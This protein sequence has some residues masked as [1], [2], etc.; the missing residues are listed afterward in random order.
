MA[1]NDDGSSASLD[2]F[3]RF[4]TPAEDTYSVVVF[5]FGSGFQANPFDST[6]GGGVGN[7]DVYELNIVLESPVLIGQ[8]ENDGAIPLAN[9]SGLTAGA[10]GLVFATG[11]IGDGP[12]G[13][14][15]T[16]TGDFDFYPVDAAAG[17]LI[18]VDIDTPCRSSARTLLSAST[19]VPGTCG[20]S[21]TTGR[22]RSTDT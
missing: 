3:L 9:Q 13:S 5:D 7:E 20:H 2:S 6:S 16:R 8:A 14:G 17:Q 1:S 12:H 15:G 10:E 22:F 11:V 21:T 18:T 4:L 19:T